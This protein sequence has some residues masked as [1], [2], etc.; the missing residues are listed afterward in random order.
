MINT[1][2]SYSLDGQI[3][4][5][6]AAVDER[7]AFLK[8]TYAW[9]G[10]G[11]LFWC[12]TMWGVQHVPAIAEMSLWLRNNYIV[13]IVLLM[14]GGFVVRMLSTKA[15]IGPV[16]YLLY[17]FFFGLLIGPL[18]AYAELAGHADVVSMASLTTGTV[19]IGLTAYVFISGKDFSWMGGALAIGLFALIAVAL[20]GWLFGFSIGVW[21]AIAAAVL[22]SGYILYDTSQILHHMPTNMHIAAAANLFVN[23]VLLFYYILMIFLSRDE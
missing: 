11:V 14:G 21:F 1:N 6:E 13:T 20:C 17:A 3:P 2:P 7:A 10:A 16:S 8:R 18:V 9:L 22:Y 15:L 4:A 19:F 12:F 23:I 5:A